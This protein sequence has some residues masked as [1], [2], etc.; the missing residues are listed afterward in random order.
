[1]GGHLPML[2]RPQKILYKISYK[3]YE[4]SGKENRKRRRL[5]QDN[6]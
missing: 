6:V 4:V 1:M 2:I 5:F 3:D